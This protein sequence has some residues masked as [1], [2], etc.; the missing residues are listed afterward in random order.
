MDA[1]MIAQ[2][3]RNGNGTHAR[4]LALG[5]TAEAIDR[6]HEVRQAMAELKREEAIL[7]DDIK[8]VMSGLA[9]QTIR[10]AETVA[11]LTTRTNLTVDPARYVAAVGLEAALPALS[12]SIEEARRQIGE[13]TLEDISTVSTCLVLSL[14]EM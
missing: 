12:V 2:T 3:T 6:L 4:T 7:T 5:D 10:T 11:R 1:T 9:L 8:A 14:E 13:R